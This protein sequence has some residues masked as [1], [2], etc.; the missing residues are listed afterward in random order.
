MT[1]ANQIWTVQEAISNMK[2][3]AKFNILWIEEPTAPDDAV[4][5]SEIAK[6]LNPIGIKVA[7]GEH[8]HNRIL[9]K[10]FNVLNGYQFVQSDPCRLGGLNELIVVCLMAKKFNKPVCLHAGGVGL[11]EM[12]V[13]M[14][15][16]DFLGI[17]GSLDQRWFE[18]SGAL[19]EHFIH[20]IKIKNGRYTVP[21]C[22]GYGCE[23]KEE[24]K[25]K[26]SYPNGSYWVSELN[27]KN[28]VNFKGIMA[29]TFAP[30][31]SDGTNLNLSLIP[32]LA[33]D[34]LKQNVT[35]IFVN[36]TSGESVSLT[37]TERKQILEK[38]MTTTP[39]KNG[40]L[41]VIAHVGTNNLSETIELAQHAQEMKVQAIAVM[42][43]S[44]FKP[45]T[46]Q[47]LANI[48]IEVA[49]KVPETAV[50]YYHIPSMNGVNIEVKSTLDIAH[51]TCGNIVGVKY[52]DSNFADL[53]R[54]ASA[55]YNVL[56]GADNMLLPALAAGADGAI[57]ITY[58]F[59]GELHN[60]IYENFHSGNVKFANFLQEHSRI[61]LDKIFGYGIYACSKYLMKTLRGF[62]LGP[63]RWP[64][65]NTN[66]EMKE[67]IAKD[68]VFTQYNENIKPKFEG[69]E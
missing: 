2:Q 66:E 65:S 69:V 22:L 14:A 15:I 28:Y 62:E 5:H 54:C 44:Y 36:G 1:D 19:H 12:G 13:H 52:T 51:S 63:L 55:G 43:P 48:L 45:K 35:G 33:N 8:A 50:Y 25:I 38:W 64:Q 40:K 10:Q 6:A 57:G 9:H 59:F 26:Y 56:V 32:E 4:G 24:T 20:P 39:V 34:L 53:G 46:V 18:Y 17:S 16:F 47:D 11:C 37:S 58:N 42:S 41:H 61:L 68:T 31:T 60:A 3:L 21:D 30:Y 27:L 49:K 29:A 67:K 7:T 23:M